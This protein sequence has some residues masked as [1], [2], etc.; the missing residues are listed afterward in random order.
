V[1]GHFA[2]DSCIIDW[3]VDIRVDAAIATRDPANIQYALESWPK[4]ERRPEDSPETYSLASARAMLFLG[5]NDEAQQLLAEIK[6]RIDASDNPYPQGWKQNAIYWPVDLPGMMG[7]IDAVRATVAD[8]EANRLPDA[9]GEI[10]YLSSIAAAYARAGDRDAAF[11]YIDRLVGRIGP[12]QYAELST[13][14]SFDGLRDDPRW[15]ALKSSY[16]AWAR[17]AGEL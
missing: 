6:A 7:D 16:E 9:W 14:V 4:E 1:A 13:D 5:K 10:D 2:R 17:E 3:L 11:G 15:L 12:W 8:A